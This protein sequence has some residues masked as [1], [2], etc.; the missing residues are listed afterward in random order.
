MRDFVGKHPLSTESISLVPSSVRQ[1][2]VHCT[3]ECQCLDRKKHQRHIPVSVN[4][5]NRVV[6]F[7]KGEG[8]T[9]PL[10]RVAEKLHQGGDSRKGFKF[11]AISRFLEVKLG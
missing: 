4:C 10:T 5:N 2:I 6:D 11:Q 3:Q 7:S 9:F 8:Y 1:S